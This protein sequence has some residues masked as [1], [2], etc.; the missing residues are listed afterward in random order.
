MA[1][2]A[3]PRV[4]GR[5][6]GVCDKWLPGAPYDRRPGPDGYVRAVRS[7]FSAPAVRPCTTWRWKMMYAARTGSIAITR[8]ANRPDQSPL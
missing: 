8:P 1:A 6:A 7:Y 2:P 3:P 5:D 4:H